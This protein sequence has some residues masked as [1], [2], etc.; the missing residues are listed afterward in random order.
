ML[1]KLAERGEVPQ[2]IE[3]LANSSAHFRPLILYTSSLL[4]D[5]VLPA[6]ARELVILRLASRADCSYMRG[7]HEPAAGA[8]GISEEEISFALDGMNEPPSSLSQAEMAALAF[9]GR[10]R[11]EESRMRQS[12]FEVIAAEWGAVVPIE[13]LFVCSYWGGLMP[14]F[15]ASLGIK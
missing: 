9:A 7:E 12:E 10:T 13:L 14:S 11:S 4:G 3:R 5:G 8:L 2:V 15:I 6:R 1:T